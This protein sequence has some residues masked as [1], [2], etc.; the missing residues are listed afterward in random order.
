MPTWAGCETVFTLFA[1]SLSLTFLHF[2]RKILL[3]LI[4]ASCCTAVFAQDNEGPTST[5][6]GRQ[7][8]RDR[9]DRTCRKLYL[10]LGTGIN[11]NTSLLGGGVDFHLSQDI[12]LNAGVG[13]LSSWGMKFYFGGKGYLKPCHKGWAF[14]AGATYNTGINSFLTKT[15]TLSGQQTV[16]LQLLPQ[17]TVYGSAYKY[18]GLGRN[19]KS[20]FYLQ[21][22]L[23]QSVTPKKFN[24]LSGPPITATSASIIR[25]IAPGGVIIG[26]GFSFGA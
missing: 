20:R 10:D 21:L 26:L 18:W 6:D 17:A 3:S 8:G 22:G 16:E 5:Y 4:I 9:Q 24:Q 7:R 15:E 11:A 19:S 13:L 25:W 14:G 1:I 23:S 12:S 2:M